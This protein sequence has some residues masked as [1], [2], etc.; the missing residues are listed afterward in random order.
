[1]PDLP[2][3]ARQSAFET[4]FEGTHTVSDPSKDAIPEEA[5]Q[6][7]AIERTSRADA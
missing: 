5:V 7:A 2:E 6:A 1:V 3:E 4:P